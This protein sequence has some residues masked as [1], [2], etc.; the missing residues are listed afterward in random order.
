MYAKTA[1]AK[2]P[3]SN[4][5]KQYA[6]NQVQNS[7]KGRRNGRST[8]RCTRRTIFRFP[9]EEYYKKIYKADRSTAKNVEVE[10]TSYGWLNAVRMGATLAAETNL[11]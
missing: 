5:F 4:K 7:K 6:M 9:S 11:R 1:K 10:A 2:G 3:S 8:E